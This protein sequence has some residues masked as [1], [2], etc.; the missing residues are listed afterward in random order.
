M[1]K[2]NKFIYYDKNWNLFK[3]NIDNV[4]EIIKNYKIYNTSLL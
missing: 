3:K 1:R 2:T 4:L